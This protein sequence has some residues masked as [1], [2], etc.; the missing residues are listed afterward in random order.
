MK[1]AGALTGTTR[2]A[3]AARGSE[4]LRCPS[5]YRPLV[6]R[7]G[8]ALAPHS[9]HRPRQSCLA[10][11]RQGPPAPVDAVQ[12]RLFELDEA[13]PT[14]PRMRRVP[15]G[16]RRRRAWLPRL[17]RWIRAQFEG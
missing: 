14:P 2:R 17:V 12:L 15:I 5:C 11:R 6:L 1:I 8:P 4:D 13:A 16:R 7:A 3:I 9:A 10:R